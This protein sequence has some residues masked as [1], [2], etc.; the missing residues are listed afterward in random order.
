MRL[1]LLK[2]LPL[3]ALPV[4]PLTLA[5]PLALALP[6]APPP[7][8][9]LQVLLLRL[10]P[11]LALRQQPVALLLDLRHPLHQLL[12][13]HLPG[14]VRQ[15]AAT[16]PHLGLH[17]QHLQTNV[18]TVQLPVQIARLQRPAH[19]ARG[20]QPPGARAVR[21]PG[22]LL[23]ALAPRPRPQ[24]L[25]A[26]RPWQGHRRRL[27]GAARLGG[28]RRPRRLLDEVPV[29]EAPPRHLLI[30]IRD[31]GQ[32]RRVAQQA[33]RAAGG[34]AV[35]GHAGGWGPRQAAGRR[36]RDG[37]LGAAPCLLLAAPEPGAQR[38]VDWR[39]RG[40]GGGGGGGG[41]AGGGRAR[42]GRGGR[43]RARLGLG[44]RCW[45]GLR[46]RGAE[47]VGVQRGD[48]Q[49]RAAEAVARAQLAGGCLQQR[50]R[51]QPRGGAQ[52]ARQLPQ[53]REAQALGR[54]RQAARRHVQH[55]H[56]VCAA[57]CR[58]GARGVWGE[59]VRV[60]VCG[61]GGGGVLARPAQ[62]RR[63]AQGRDASAR[64]S[65]SPAVVAQ[66]WPPCC[67]CQARCA[68]HGA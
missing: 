27:G 20:A 31:G 46:A 17:L 5:L 68:R 23:W 25:A 57:A 49:E 47:R 56:V 7:L 34:L 8:P 26:G 14:R 36:L 35:P 64:S 32:A 66:L 2:R 22:P 48:E 41:G 61:G 58:G 40:G 1:P 30:H 51:V 11:L 6:G 54:A 59:G 12:Q 45:R 62:A 63:G 44:R 15:D 18:A 16:L 33:A 65:S 42:R 19:A 60:C 4:L 53:R 38:P 9:Q 10:P 50:L 28:W 3:L 13:L 55:A 39:S 67:C 37:P 21:L 29:H 24:R 43:G 52:H